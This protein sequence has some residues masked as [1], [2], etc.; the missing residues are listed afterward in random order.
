MC[1]LLKRETLPDA[2]LGFAFLPGFAGQGYAS[3]AAAAV[4]A[5]ARQTLGLARVLAI[6][7][8]DN[9]RSI[10]LLERIGFRFEGMLQLAA[11]D[12]VRLFEYTFE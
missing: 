7:S 12:Q 5:Y 1:G 9:T 11:D 10:K 3:E 4:L 8:P 2:D 6:T